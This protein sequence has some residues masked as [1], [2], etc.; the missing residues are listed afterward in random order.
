MLVNIPEELKALPQWVVAYQHDNDFLEQS[1]RKI[2]HDPKSLQHASVTDPSTWGTFQEASAHNKPVGFVLTKDDPYCIIDLDNP[3]NEEQKERHEKIMAEIDSYQEISISGKGIHIIVRGEIPK[4]CRKEKVEVYSSERYMI[5]TGHI[6]GEKKPIKDAQEIVSSIYQQIKGQDAYHNGVVPDEEETQ[7]DEK[8]CEIATGAVNGKE[9]LDLW[10]G[11][12]QN[13]YPSQSEADMALMAHLCF[14]SKNNEQVVRLFRTSKLGKR[15]KAKR[16]AYLLGLIHKIRLNEPKM[17]NLDHIKYVPPPPEIKVEEVPALPV[18]NDNMF[19]PGIVGEIADYI[20]KSSIRPVKEIALASAIALTAGI[21]GRSYNV[22]SIGLNQYVIMLARTGCGKEGGAKGIEALI[23]EC[24]KTVPMTD[25]FMGPSAFASGQALIKQLDESPCFIS[26]LGEF[27]L[28]LQ[29]I[30]DPKAAAP[31]IMLKK[32]LLDLYSKSGFQSILRPSA[33][34]DQT[35]N[36][37]TVQAPNLTILGESTPETF[38]KKLNEEHI[39]EGL[40]PRFT[41]IQYKGGRPKKNK[42]PFFNPDNSLVEK[43]NNLLTCALTAEQQNTVN[44]VEVAPDAEHIL[45]KFD[46]YADE[47][48]NGGSSEIEMQIWNRSHLK[49]IKLSAL[50]AV[51]VNPYHPRV[52]ESIADWACKLVHSECEG[53]QEAFETNSMGEGEHTHE[54]HVREII[55]SY[56][57]MDWGK[58]M[59]YR[60]NENLAKTN[61]IPLQYIRK[62]A[63]KLSTFK[64]DKRGPVKALEICINDLISCGILQEVPYSQKNGLVRG[65]AKIYVTGENY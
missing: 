19:P 43:I 11:E 35:K 8:I 50:I 44:Q 30:C 10:N 61:M 32:V 56:L 34:S 22:S 9:F 51:G 62:R 6:F 63:Q 14:Y 45:D 58:R 53:I 65:D 7:S 42:N 1:E 21:V 55:D 60:V 54:T 26:I 16:N 15:D 3:I 52:D 31:L 37:S 46:E 13:K 27:G 48:M 28:T 38:F 2:P 57:Q 4:G 23:R 40:I 47:K 64:N 12:W 36:T 41:V 5:T 17:I 29:Q 59:S 33:Y 39:A 49:A 25:R 24:S 18:T 20:Y